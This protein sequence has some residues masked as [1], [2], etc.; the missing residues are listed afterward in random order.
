MSP[1]DP[2]TQAGSRQQ[3][4]RRGRGVPAAPP[5]STSQSV[6]VPVTEA[7]RASPADATA[8]INGKAIDSAKVGIVGLEIMVEFT[9]PNRQ[10]PQVPIQCLR[11]G[12]G[13]EFHLP[14]ERV[15]VPEGAT[16]ACLTFSKRHKQDDG[17]VVVLKGA[18]MVEVPLRA[19]YT[20]R[21]R[22]YETVGCAIHGTVS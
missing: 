22:V 13:G 8:V 5:D 12:E 11:T 14:C 10:R 20:L 19:T 6:A 16:A 17:R 9:F 18:E 7:P 2:R 4:R 15:S 21:D 1:T 3:G